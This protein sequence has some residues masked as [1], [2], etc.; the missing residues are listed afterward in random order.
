[1]NRP[2]TAKADWSSRALRMPAL[3]LAPRSNLDAASVYA[4]RF[5][6]AVVGLVVVVI[7]L[8]LAK[9]ILAPIFLAIVFGL[10]LGPI[11]D[12]LERFGVP[13]W[14]SALVVVLLLIGLVTVVA[15]GFA[16]PLSEWV[17]RLPDAWTRL[18]V[19]LASWKSLFSSL[20]GLQ[21]QI[22]EIVGSS[23]VLAVKVEDSTAVT[24]V[25]TAAPAILS[26]ALIFVAG[27][28]FYLATRSR[29][30][31]A[32]L[33]LCFSRRVRWRVARIFRD[34]EFLV[35]RYLLS[36]TVINIG[37]GAATAAAMWLLGVPAP[38]LWGLLAGILNYIFYLGPAVM[39]VVLIGVG[40]V[41]PELAAAPLLPAAVYLGL[42]F[43]E[44]Q[45]VTPHVLGLTMTI[46]PFMIFLSIVFWLWLWGPLGGFVAIP[47]LLILHVI[48]QHSLPRNGEGRPSQASATG[49]QLQIAPTGLP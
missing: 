7:A 15:T 39:A 36:I 35:S 38:L 11:A 23:K 32:V 3:R 46:N 22:Q 9:M 17:D 45:F 18:Q 27:L 2:V 44:T 48:L 42:H 10:M 31:T 8:S 21:Q 13:T 47:S 30:R 49:Q 24:T 16:V 33:S 14:L 40:L 26:Q 6:N 37:L 28:Y 19:Y 20:S 5:S 25:A 4:S 12:R 43:I 34:V 29:F 1:M 41:S